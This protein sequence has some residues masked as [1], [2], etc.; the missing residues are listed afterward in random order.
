MRQFTNLAKDNKGR[1]IGR[2][3][4][5]TEDENGNI[6]YPNNH[7]K[8][9][10]GGIENLT[11]HKILFEGTQFTDGDGQTTFDPTN[12]IDPTK[13]VTRKITS[14]GKNNRLIVE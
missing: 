11:L 1:K 8:N 6:T 2:T 14:S 7:Y 3:I 13:P 5:F 9:V 4:Q 10:C 12:Q